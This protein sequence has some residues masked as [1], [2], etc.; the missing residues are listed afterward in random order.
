MYVS[1]VACVLQHMEVR[2]QHLGVSLLLPL[3][4]LGL[5]SGHQACEARPWALQSSLEGI[6][7]VCAS[8]T[9]YPF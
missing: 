3:R 5:N 1:V 8:D 9:Q 7:D 2:G 4:V 6:N